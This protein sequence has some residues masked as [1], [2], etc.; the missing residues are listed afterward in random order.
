M[1]FSDSRIQKLLSE[2]YRGNILFDELFKEIC[3]ITYD[4][5]DEKLNN[6]GDIGKVLVKSKVGKRIELVDTNY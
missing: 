2:G 3:S 4:K 1:I 5:A 6:I